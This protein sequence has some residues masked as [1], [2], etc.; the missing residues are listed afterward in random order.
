V[1]DS[2]RRALNWGVPILVLLAIIGFLLT[3]SDSPADPSFRPLGAAAPGATDTPATSVPGRTRVAGFGEITYRVDST[4]VLFGNGA[5]SVSAARCA[6]LAA[7]AAQQNQGLMGRTDLSGY[8]GMLFR[9]DTDSQAEFYMKDTLVPLSIA[10]FD[11]QGRFISTT[12]M[13]PCGDQPVCPT[14]GAEAAYRY[15][16][17]VLEG[18]L[19]ALGIGPGTRLVVGRES[20]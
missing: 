3:G 4:G 17:E 11:A 6:L 14:F 7:T 12:D 15:A 20:C 2:T 16:L 13:P 1:T 9:F 8:D 18:G 19:P 10:W 5:G